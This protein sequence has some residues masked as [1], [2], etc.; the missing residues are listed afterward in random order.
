MSGE[1]VDG[2]TFEGV[3][4]SVNIGYDVRG[5]MGLVSFENI[6]TTFTVLFIKREMR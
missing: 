5:L 4:R 3:T 6:F 1:M 2:I